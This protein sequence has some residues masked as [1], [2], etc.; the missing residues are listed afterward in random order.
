[1]PNAN[2][3]KGVRLERDVVNWFKSVG[4]TAART[5]GS[6]GKYDLYVIGHLEQISPIKGG[7]QRKGDTYTDTLYTYNVSDGVTMAVFIQCKRKQKGE[8]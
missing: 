1:M 4:C 5:A 2:Y 7:W 6:H 8:K 3:Q